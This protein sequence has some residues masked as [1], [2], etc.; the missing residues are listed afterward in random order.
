MAKGEILYGWGK[1]NDALEA[2]EKASLS[3]P[4]AGKAI[5]MLGICHQAIGEYEKASALFNSRD[6]IQKQSPVDAIALT[7]T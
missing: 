3:Q 4:D 6:H 5:W 7:L 1:V 2:F